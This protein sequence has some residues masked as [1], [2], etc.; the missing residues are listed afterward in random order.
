MIDGVFATSEDGQVQFAEAAALT[1]QDLAAVQRQVR[2][3]AA[4]VRPR[5]SS[6]ARAH[7]RCYHQRPGAP[8]IL[9]QLG[10]SLGTGLA[11]IPS[12]SRELVQPGMI[13]A[14]IVCVDDRVRA[15]P[16]R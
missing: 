1:P 7:H 2:A 5:R 12:P 6:R 9:S 13:S 14:T 4:L 11:I 16:V 15:R 3:R 10:E 8:K